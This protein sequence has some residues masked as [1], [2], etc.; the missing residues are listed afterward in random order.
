MILAN[1]RKTHK[2][3]IT[4]TTITVVAAQTHAPLTAK[5]ACSV[6]AVEYGNMPKYMELIGTRS[7]QRAS[8]VG[9]ADVD[10]VAPDSSHYPVDERELRQIFGT[11]HDADPLNLNEDQPREGGGSAEEE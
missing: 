3:P 9:E 8:G 2:Q 7:H 10:V 11:P 1:G 5:G 4:S 6:H